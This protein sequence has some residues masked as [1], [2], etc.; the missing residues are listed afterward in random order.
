MHTI[1]FQYEQASAKLES[2]TAD[3]YLIRNLWSKTRRR[4]HAREV[5]KKIVD[6]ADGHD[7]TLRIVAQPY[8]K[9]DI[10]NSADLENFYKTFGFQRESDSPHHPAWMIRY[11]EPDRG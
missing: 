9:G 10:L 3:L 5:M 6:Y 4:G 8:G 2:L 11:P 7:I 1:R